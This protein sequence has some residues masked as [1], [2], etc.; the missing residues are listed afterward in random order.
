MDTVTPP[1]VAVPGKPI[2][3]DYTPEGFL[4]AVHHPEDVVG[5]QEQVRW[6]YEVDTGAGRIGLVRA[7]TRAANVPAL[8]ERTEFTYDRMGRLEE[9]R[10]PA[11][12]S[13]AVA[14]LYF[15]P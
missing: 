1:V 2:R 5:G 11:M 12:A 10:P 9:L 8:A 7:V 13:D 14:P 6:D 4:S 15:P 3:H